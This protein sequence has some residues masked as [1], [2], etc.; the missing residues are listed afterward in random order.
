[1]EY[2]QEQV[3]LPQDIVN[4]IISLNYS[5]FQLTSKQLYMAAW[6]EQREQFIE[7]AK[8]CRFD[9]DIKNGIE[10]SRILGPEELVDV[11]IDATIFAQPE[12]C[13]SR[14]DKI[15]CEIQIKMN[16]VILSFHKK[17]SVHF[18]LSYCDPLSNS[19]SALTLC[20]LTSLQSHKDFILKMGRNFPLKMRQIIFNYIFSGYSNKWQDVKSMLKKLEREVIRYYN[21]DKI[22][23][24]IDAFKKGNNKINGKNKKYSSYESI[25]LEKY[26]ELVT[27]ENFQL[28]L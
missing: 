8:Y 17:R 26:Y 5:A 1:M 13:I 9:F 21:Y 24:S 10:S 23:V 22:K 7:A 28:H 20:D 12:I 15:G 3:Q 6:N 4:F 27:N 19:V 16:G 14:H 18:E 2:Q 25:T 11:C